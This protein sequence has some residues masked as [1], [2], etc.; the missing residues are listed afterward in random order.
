[1]TRFLAYLSLGLALTLVGTGVFVQ[2]LRAANRASQL[3]ARNARA[4]ADSTRH[5]TILFRDSAVSVHQRLVE[6][7]QV[8]LDGF[9]EALRRERGGRAVANA[10]IALLGDSLRE[11]HANAATARDTAGTVIVTDT[12]NALDSLGVQADVQVTIPPTGLAT[13]RWGFQRAPVTLDLTLTCLTE[14]A[15]ATLTG[16]PWLEADLGR[17]QMDDVICVPP[18]RAWNPLSFKVPGVPWLAAVGV[19]GFLI[20]Q[21]LP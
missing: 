20:G 6:E 3:E 17:V 8:A 11:L 21:A 16:P 2:H 10:R 13:V 14:N 15:E 5:S 12:L 4:D 19:L 9:Q 1:M 7:R 18:V